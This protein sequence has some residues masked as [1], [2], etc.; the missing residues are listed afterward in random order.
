MDFPSEM[1]DG[2]T[3][4]ATGSTVDATCARTGMRCG[5]ARA[6]ARATLRGGHGSAIGA[7]PRPT[8]RTRHHQYHFQVGWGGA[9]EVDGLRN[10]S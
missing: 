10:G 8:N 4:V 9:G 3:D 1:G 6:T 2:A 5:N 7:R